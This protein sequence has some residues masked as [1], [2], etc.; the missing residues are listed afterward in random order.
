MKNFRF[1]ELWLLS[2]KSGTARHLKWSK[3]KNALVGS[4]HTGKSTALRMIYEAFGCKTRPL[5]AEWDSGAV[6][7][8]SFALGESK[9]HMLRRGMM[10]ALF[11]HDG[12]LEWALDDA[13]ELRKR[14][15]ELFEFVL[16]LTNQK[17]ESR[18]ARPAFFFLPH[19][20]DQD[21]GWNAF[22]QTFQSQANSAIGRDLR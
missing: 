22:W 17:G 12:E 6:T 14:F 19:F 4:N 11:R 7:V 5:G 21:G 2:E 15:S 20:I 9:Y 18:Q 16:P 3:G 10:F 8:V 13:G 1:D